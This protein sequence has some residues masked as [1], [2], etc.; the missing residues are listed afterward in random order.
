MAEYH[1]FGKRQWKYRLKAFFTSKH[2]L[3]RL[4]SINIAV[5]IFC[6]LI[7]LLSNV[8][9]FL[10]ADHTSSASSWIWNWLAV[11]SNWQQVLFKPWTLIT[12]LFVHANFS[13]IL[14]NMLTLYFAGT[15]FTRYFSDKQLYIVY[16]IGGIIGNI[17]YILSYNYFP[18]FEAVRA[19]SFAV[20]ASG[21]IMAILVAIACKAPNDYVNLLFLGQIK[22]KWIAIFFVIIDI[23]S[24]PHG[25]SGGHF[26]HLGGALFGCCYVLVPYLKNTFTIYKRN[27]SYTPPPY[28]NR[29]KSDESYN[30]ER[31][32]YRKKVDEILDKIAKDGYQSLSKEE[33]EFLFNT[34]NKKNW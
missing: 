6:L 15:F 27:T 11:S 10:Y 24:I 33:K 13:H 8:T 29:P 14:F 2:A 26:A 32:Q 4:I 30:A 23:L 1:R 21:A 22:L 28:Q 5:Y 9:D 31:A 20:G 12:S 25:N 34:S 7:Q 17:L 19:S 18:V 3:N 16:F